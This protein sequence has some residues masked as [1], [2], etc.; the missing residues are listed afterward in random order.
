[1]KPFLFF[2]SPFAALIHPLI[3]ADTVEEGNGLNRLEAGGTCMF[4]LS[5]RSRKFKVR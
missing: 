5:G 1:M 4:G 3:T 2:L